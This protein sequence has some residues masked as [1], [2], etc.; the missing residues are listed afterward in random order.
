MVTWQAVGDGLEVEVTFDAEDEEAWRDFQTKGFGIS[1][2]NTLPVSVETIGKESNVSVAIGSD[3]LET[4]RRRHLSLP[5]TYYAAIDGVLPADDSLRELWERFK[6]SS[7]TFVRNFIAYHHFRRLGW[8]PKSGLNYGAHYVLYRGSATDF[9]SEYIVYV[10]DEEEDSSWN[11]IQSLTRIAADVKKTV[12][13]CTVTAATRASEES[14]SVDTD[15]TFGVYNFHDVQYTVEAIAIRFWDPSIADG[16]QSYTFQQQPV[17]PKK[18]KTAKKKN[19]AKRPKRQL[20]GET[21][22]GSGKS[23]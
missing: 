8:A 5:E 2:L 16:A 17:I 6:S 21:L 12:L 23:T 10:Q 15:L 3:T 1:A 20:E 14:G 19:R 13:L 4:K 7:T 22:T 11:T 18:P 9:H